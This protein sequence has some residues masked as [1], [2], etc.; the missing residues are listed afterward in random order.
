MSRFTDFHNISAQFDALI[1]TNSNK[2]TR[3]PISKKHHIFMIISRIDV[4][5]TGGIDVELVSISKHGAL[6]GCN[7][8]ALHNAKEKNLCIEIELLLNDKCFQYESH[9]VSQ[10]NINNFHGIKFEQTV[11]AIE[12]YLIEYQLH[13]YYSEEI[14]KNSAVWLQLA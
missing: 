4:F 9:I 2:E 1:N 12:H 10:D 5:K 13:P 7:H 3:V 14:P 6:F 8:H 11:E